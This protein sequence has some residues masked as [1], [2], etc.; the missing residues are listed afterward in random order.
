VH[1][2]ESSAQLKEKFEKSGLRT[3]QIETKLITQS[4]SAVKEMFESIKKLGASNAAASR[5]PISKSAYR[6]IQ[7][8]FQQQLEKDKR[9]TLTFEV[10]SFEAVQ[11]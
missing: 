3:K 6:S 5:K 1:S 11:L 10:I 2:F 7:N 9:L 4:F 8:E